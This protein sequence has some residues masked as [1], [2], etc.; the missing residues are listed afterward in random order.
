MH[1]RHLSLVALV[2][3]LIISNCP[4][5][6]RVCMVSVCCIVALRLSVDYP[7]GRLWWSVPDRER[8]PM[9]QPRD[10]QLHSDTLP[11]LLRRRAG[12][13]S[14]FRFVSHFVSVIPVFTTT[15][16]QSFNIVARPFPRVARGAWSGGETTVCMVSTDFD[17]TTHVTQSQI[18]FRYYAD[19]CFR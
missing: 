1:N 4:T 19:L 10:Q 11:S 8:L 13:P 9:D 3:M 14:S 2:E 16:L 18:E 15:Q 7:C 5:I 6:R 17:K 12:S